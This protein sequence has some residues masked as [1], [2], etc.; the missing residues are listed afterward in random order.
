MPFKSADHPEKFQNYLSSYSI[1]SI[2]HSLTEVYPCDFWM[3]STLTNMTAGQLNVLLPG[4][5]DHY[6]ANAPVN[7]FATFHEITDFK[8]FESTQ[9]MRAVLTFDLQFWA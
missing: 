7:V 6:G 9:E 8:V 3:N 2:F 5:S 4:I 1:N